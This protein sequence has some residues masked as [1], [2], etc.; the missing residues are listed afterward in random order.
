MHIQNAPCENASCNSAIFLVFSNI[1]LR[2]LYNVASLKRDCDDPTRIPTKEP[3]IEKRYEKARSKGG[4]L[5][6]INFV[7]RGIARG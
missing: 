6:G 7:Q 2:S 4:D 5:D 1:L 3:F